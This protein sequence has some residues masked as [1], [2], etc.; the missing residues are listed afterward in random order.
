MGRPR[1]PTIDASLVEACAQLLGEVGRATLT[2]QLVA[3]RAGVS[4][5][6]VT[7]RFLSVDDLILAVAARPPKT[8]P[9]PDQPADLQPYLVGVLRDLVG[10]AESGQRRRAIAEVTAAAASDVRIARALNAAELTARSGPLEVLRSAQDRRELS[11]AIDVEQL[12][13][14]LLGAVRYRLLWFGDQISEPYL[15]GLVKHALNPEC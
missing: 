11:T 12:L 10:D 1:D 3:R 13:D 15:N 14:H 8:R 7:R 2:R 5:P 4:L 9:A 6:A